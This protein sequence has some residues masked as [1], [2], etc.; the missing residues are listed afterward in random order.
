MLAQVPD[1]PLV[2]AQ[3]ALLAAPLAAGDGVSRC[4]DRL[5]HPLEVERAGKVVADRG[6][7]G[8][9]IVGVERD[10]VGDLP[11]DVEDGLFPRSERRHLRT[12]AAAGDQLDRRIDQAHRLAGF[13]RQP[14]VLDRGLL[15]DLPRAVHLVAQA[16][17]PDAVWLGVAVGGPP[18]RVAAAGRGVAVLDQVAG[19]IDP[20]RAQVDGEH[21][22]GAGAVSYTHLRAHETR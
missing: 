14:A 20:A 10:V 17:E 2:H 6:V 1:V 9:V 21:R 11:R 5:D 22:L 19:S 12:G 18:V 16:P 7:F 15:A 13:R 8:G 3:A 4:G